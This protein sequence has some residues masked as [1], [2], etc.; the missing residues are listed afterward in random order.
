MA[1][2]YDKGEQTWKR[3]IFDN[4]ELVFEKTWQSSLETS[5]PLDVRYEMDF[6]TTEAEFFNTYEMM[7]FYSDDL[8]SH[9]VSTSI[10]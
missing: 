2:V 4:E 10:D 9:Y 6:S 8:I 7:T 3:E 5:A 1:Q